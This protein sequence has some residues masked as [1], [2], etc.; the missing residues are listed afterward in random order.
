MRGISE[1]DNLVDLPDDE[2]VKEGGPNPDM[3]NGV[4]GR[5]SHQEE[6]KQQALTPENSDQLMRLKFSECSSI[7]QSYSHNK[8]AAKDK[9]E[10]FP[11][12]NISGPTSKF[13]LNFKFLDDKNASLSNSKH[14]LSRH[15]ED[16]KFKGKSPQRSSASN[17][18]REFQIFE[19]PYMRS[20]T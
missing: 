14:S 6:E 3:S 19:M 13:S 15:L 17:K 1:I 16:I 4:F 2:E 11:S 18:P 7:S 12:P 8:A 9:S 5:N 20:N 10:A